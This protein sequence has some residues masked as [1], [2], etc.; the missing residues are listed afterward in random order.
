MGLRSTV[1]YINAGRLPSVKFI[2][3]SFSGI[4]TSLVWHTGDSISASPFPPSSNFI[5]ARTSTLTGSDIRPH[6]PG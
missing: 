1:Y 5:M 6:R 2:L 3:T 4:R